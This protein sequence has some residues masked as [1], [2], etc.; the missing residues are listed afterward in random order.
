MKVINIKS[1]EFIPVTSNSGEDTDISTMF[2]GDLL[3]HVLGKAIDGTVLITVLT[4]INTLAVASL[5]N[6][7]AIIFVDGVQIPDELIK[8]AELEN[9]TLF[10]TT[11]SAKDT[12]I[13]LYKKGLE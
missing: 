3:S 2:V 12:V 13:S 10:K 4:N 7:P 11:L 9:I 5:L 8:K 6:F 1:E